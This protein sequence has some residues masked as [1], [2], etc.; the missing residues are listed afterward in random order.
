[1]P[2]FIPFLVLALAIVG[3]PVQSQSNRFVAMAMAFVDATREHLELRYG[4]SD[5]G[6]WG[7]LDTRR[8]CGSDL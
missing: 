5:D 6:D 4:S 7:R 8:T 3:T 2:R 1:M